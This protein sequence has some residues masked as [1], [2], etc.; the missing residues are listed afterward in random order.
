MKAKQSKPQRHS[1]AL[2][3]Q[4]QKEQCCLLLTGQRHCGRVGPEDRVVVH[5]RLHRLGQ[6]KGHPLHDDAPVG[7]EQLQGLVLTSN[8][9]IMECQ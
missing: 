1:L 8:D 3:Q 6:V 7:L 9:T 5:G 2:G 4:V